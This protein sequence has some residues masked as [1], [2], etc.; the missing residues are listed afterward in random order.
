MCNW[1]TTLPG[2]SKQKGDFRT[3][4]CFSGTTYQSQTEAFR[5]RF[6]RKSASM[7]D[8]GRARRDRQETMGVLNRTASAR[9]NSRCGVYQENRTL[10]KTSISIS[11]R[12]RI[13][14]NQLINHDDDS[15]VCS[16]EE[17]SWRVTRVDPQ[18]HEELPQRKRSIRNLLSRI[19]RRF[20]L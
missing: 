13:S 14:N 2:K 17:N 3:I 16:L 7:E 15:S 20:K 12:T 5:K 9:I 11:T 6:F 1:K 4:E 19:K 10:S 8:D 18:S